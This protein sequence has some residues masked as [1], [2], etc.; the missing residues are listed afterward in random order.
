MIR[1]SIRVFLQRGNRKESLLT[2]TGEEEVMRPSKELRRSEFNKD[3]IAFDALT[4]QFVTGR[5]WKQS[6]SRNSCCVCRFQNFN[7]PSSEAESKVALSGSASSTVTFFE[8]ADKC[9]IPAEFVSSM[10]FWSCSA[11][12]MSKGLTWRVCNESSEKLQ[13]ESRPRLDPVTTTSREK[14]EV[15]HSR[16]CVSVTFKTTAARWTS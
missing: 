9:V 2:K 7:F 11:G 3:V 15:T 6:I 5:P 10:R 14:L 16:G 12:K 13:K 1:V 8:C 4:W